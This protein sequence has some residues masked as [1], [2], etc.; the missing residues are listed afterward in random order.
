MVDVENLIIKE[1]SAEVENLPKSEEG[2]LRNMWVGVRN[3]WWGFTS[4]P[5]SN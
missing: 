3:W 5:I 4:K 2:I 1:C